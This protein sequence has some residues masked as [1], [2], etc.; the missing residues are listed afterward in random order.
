LKVCVEEWE[1]VAEATYTKHTGS[2]RSAAISRAK[3]QGSGFRGK[4]GTDRVAPEP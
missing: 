1:P 3:E 2:K 4:Q